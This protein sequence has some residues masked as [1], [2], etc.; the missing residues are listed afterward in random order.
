MAGTDSASGPA[1]ARTR[2]TEIRTP[3]TV[4]LSKK[5]TSASLL[6]LDEDLLVVDKPAF[7]LSQDI[8]ERPKATTIPV[9]VTDL[10]Q[11]LGEDR[12]IHLVHRLDEETTG[13][14]L[15]ARNLE[16]KKALEKLFHSHDLERIYHALVQGRP[17][18]QQG[19]MSGRLDTKGER[20]VV[21][22]HGGE[23]AITHYA[24]VATLPTFSVVACKLETGKRNQIRAHLADRGNVLIGDRKFGH[25]TRMPG[26]RRCLLH[27]TALSLV[28]PRTGQRMTAVAPFPEDMRQLLGDEL[29]V[30]LLPG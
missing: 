13:A 12:E 2:S 16:T 26:V 8:A 5:L 28:H 17:H 23:R 7:V 21:V 30:S 18:P 4:S 10:L 3:N 25:R 14:L 15:L 1:S 22:P 19:T 6:H 11:E 27:A 29:A 24:L 20:A 9:L